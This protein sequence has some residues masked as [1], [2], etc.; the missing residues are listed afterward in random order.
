MSRLFVSGNYEG[1][2]DS[3]LQHLTGVDLTALQ[4]AHPVLDEFI[5]VRRRGGGEGGGG[6]VVSLHSV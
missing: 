6:V 2:I 1:I 5:K 4:L 3:I